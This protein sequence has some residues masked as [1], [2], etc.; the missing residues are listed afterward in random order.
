MTTLID[1]IIIPSETL[2]TFVFSMFLAIVLGTAIAL[3][4]RHT[5]RGLN[6]ESSFLPTL[7]V[8]S[9]IVTLVMFFIQGDLVLS[10][11]LVGSLSIIRFR[12]PIKDTRDM[13]FL[14]WTIAI[15]LGIGT[16][17]WTIA[18]LATLILGALMLV[19]YLIK[20]GRPI[21]AEYIL[22]ISGERRFDD[23]PMK[24]LADM[25]GID[26]QLRSR[27]QE[28]DRYEIIFE[29]RFDKT[30]LSSIDDTVHLLQAAEGVHKVSLLAPQLA[31]PM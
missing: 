29:L 10:L 16:Q 20:Y 5:H 22:I 17:N 1:Q 8:L 18:V 3:I 24:T 30:K 15:G 21:H 27:E 23:T 19:F 6:Y 11:G 28:G 4:Y 2:L 26:V 25:G 14:F 31:L 9:P 13:A 7:V 12:T